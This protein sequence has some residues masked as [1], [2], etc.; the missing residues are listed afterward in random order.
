MRRLGWAGWL[1]RRSG[2]GG[3]RVGGV[4]GRKKAKTSNNKPR[5]ALLTTGA[6]ADAHSSANATTSCS[7]LSQAR[8][9][10][11]LVINIHFSTMTT[12]TF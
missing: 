8:L 3:N 1:H 11:V 4:Y 10:G 5:L 2:F 12:H 9:D 7:A 6:D